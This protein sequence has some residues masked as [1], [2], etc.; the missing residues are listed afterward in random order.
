MGSF[1]PCGVGKMSPA[2]TQIEVSSVDLELGRWLG[3]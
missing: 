2:E 3:K 1:D